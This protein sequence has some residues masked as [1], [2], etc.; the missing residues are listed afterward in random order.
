MTVWC[1]AAD[2]PEGMAA[3]AAEQTRP[4]SRCETLLPRSRT[5]KGDLL[6]AVANSSCMAGWFFFFFNR[7]KSCFIIMKHTLVFASAIS[8]YRSKPMSLSIW[9][10]CTLEI[11]LGYCCFKSVLLGAYECDWALCKR[12]LIDRLIDASLQVSTVFDLSLS[13]TWESV[14]NLVKSFRFCPR[15]KANPRVQAYRKL[16]FSIEESSNLN[17]KWQDIKFSVFFRFI[18]GLQSQKPRPLFLLRISKPL[19]SLFSSRNLWTNLS[20]DH[21]NQGIN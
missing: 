16:I 13:P 1:V 14:L 19:S 7:G 18:K 5:K 9:G 17:L 6:V 2:R 11:F 12:E 8:S 4:S 20:S 3:A 10:S 15:L 21:W